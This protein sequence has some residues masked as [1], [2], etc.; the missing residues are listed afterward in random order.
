VDQQQIYGQVPMMPPGQ[1]QIGNQSNIVQVPNQQYSQQQPIV[2]TQGGKKKKKTGQKVL[3]ALIVALAV[4]L[5]VG[6]IA[7]TIMQCKQAKEKIDAEN[8]AKEQLD[9]KNQANEASEQNA[10]LQKPELIK[11]QPELIIDKSGGELDGYTAQ[12]VNNNVPTNNLDTINQS[13]SQST[14]VGG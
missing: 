12:S 8:Q 13:Q 3:N 2:I 6:I 4:I 14:S 5:V 7:L 9:A 11:Q 10:E 1:Q